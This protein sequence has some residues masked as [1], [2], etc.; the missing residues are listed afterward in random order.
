MNTQAENRLIAD[1]LAQ[2]HPLPSRARREWADAYVAM[3]P[4]GRRFDAVRVP[5]ARVHAAVAGE[6]PATVAAALKDWLRGP[7]IRDLRSPLGAYYFLVPPGAEWDGPEARLSTGTYLGVPRVGHIAY[8]MTWVVPPEHPGNLCDVAA[9]H[10]LL[11]TADPLPTAG[12][13]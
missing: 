3:I 2:A 8:L 10:T 12:R 5:A 1:W 4:L 11:A 13:R 7:V 6:E 9:L